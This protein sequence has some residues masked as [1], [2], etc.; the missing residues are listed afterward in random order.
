MVKNYNLRGHMFLMY[1][2]AIDNLNDLIS[3]WMKDTITEKEYNFQYHRIWIIHSAIR[4]N[5]IYPMNKSR[6]CIKN[7]ISNDK[8]GFDKNEQ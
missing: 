8:M 6:D 4:H 3:K 7:W 5:I 1:E 2:K